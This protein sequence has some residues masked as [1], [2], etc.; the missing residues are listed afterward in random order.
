MLTRPDVV[1]GAQGHLV[2]RGAASLALTVAVREDN[3]RPRR[4]QSLPAT[5]IPSVPQPARAQRVGTGVTRG[6]RA[7]VPG[8]TRASAS[9]K[10]YAPMIRPAGSTSARLVCPQI[11]GRPAYAKSAAVL[12]RP[13]WFQGSQPSAV[14]LSDPS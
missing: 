7:T 12:T 14:P 6:S 11:S 4:H 10:G 9:A 1:D 3:P 2:L 8:E 13:S 5:G